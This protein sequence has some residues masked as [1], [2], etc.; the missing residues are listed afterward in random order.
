M[1]SARERASLMPTRAI[2]VTLSGHEFGFGYEKV[3]QRSEK[4]FSD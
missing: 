4:D 1:M 2:V 3:R